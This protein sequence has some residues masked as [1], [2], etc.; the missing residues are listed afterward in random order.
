MSGGLPET[1]RGWRLHGTGLEALL[2]DTIPLHPP[3]ADQV[4][5]RVD[6]LSLCYSDVKIALLGDRHPRM[7][8][9]NLEADP[10]TLGLEIAMTVV[11][12]GVVW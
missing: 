11:A 7:A 10:L 5:F 6:A 9:R 3:E 4:L 2:L 1:Y 12:A 8:G